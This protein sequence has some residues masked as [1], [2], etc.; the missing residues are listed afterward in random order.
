MTASDIQ[1]DDDIRREEY[2]EAL[3]EAE[4]RDHEEEMED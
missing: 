3:E 1:F 4:N 2:A